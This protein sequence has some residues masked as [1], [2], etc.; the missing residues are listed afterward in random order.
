MNNRFLK[1]LT[2]VFVLVCIFHF[3]VFA[4]IYGYTTISGTFESIED[5]FYTESALPSMIIKD[6]LLTEGK[7]SAEFSTNINSLPM[8][9]IVFRGN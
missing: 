5:G 6:E 7:I 8:G 9:G 4:E 1:I 3:S 2:L